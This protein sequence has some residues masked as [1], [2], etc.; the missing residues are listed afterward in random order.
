MIDTV[1]VTTPALMLGI[2]AL[3]KAPNMVDYPISTLTGATIINAKTPG[4]RSADLRPKIGRYLR[5]HLGKKST[6][7]KP[8]SWTAR[9]STSCPA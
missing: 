6:Q 9:R 7:G 1:L 3:T 5:G 8:A 4:A 2:Q